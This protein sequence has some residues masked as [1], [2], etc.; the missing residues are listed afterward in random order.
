LSAVSIMPL[1]TPKRLMGWLI[2]RPLARRSCRVTDPARAPP[3]MSV[4]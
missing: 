4:V 3:R 2:T 1:I